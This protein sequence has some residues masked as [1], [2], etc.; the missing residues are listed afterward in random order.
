[1]L[2]LTKEYAEKFYKS[3]PAD[4]EQ[5][6]EELKRGEYRALGMLYKG[7]AHKDGEIV[8]RVAEE[9]GGFLSGLDARRLIRLEETFRQYSSLEWSIRWEAIE[10]EILKE[11]ILR[12][13]DYLWVIRLGTFHPN[14]YFR[15]NCIWALARDKA[16]QKYIIL[17]LND[18]VK[19][20]REAARIVSFGIEELNV[21]ALVE[22]LP[23]LEKVKQG[24]RREG[25]SFFLLEE[26]IA[27]GISTQLQNVDLL[28]LNQ[29]DAGTRKVLYGLL[30]DWKVLD[31]AEVNLILGREK[32][33][34]CL[35]FIMH[36]FLS[37]YELTAEELDVYLLHKNK[38]IQRRALEQKYRLMKDY[39]EGLEELLLAPSIGVRS[40]VCY[41]L[42]R[43]TEIEIV[44]FYKERLQT[45]N[46]KI[47]ILGI[48]ENGNPE[49]VQDLLPF[50]QEENGSI[51]KSALKAISMLVGDEASD[52]YWEYLQDER[53]MVIAGAYKEI[54]ANEIRYGAKKVYELLM[55]ASSDLLRDK[56]IYL[57]VRERSWDRLPYL[58]RLYQ[59]EDVVLR[60]LLHSGINRRSLYERVSVEA[61]EE[62]RRILY[63]EK[64][65]IPEK[66]QKSIEFDLKFVTK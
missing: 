53:P 55:T 10:P 28:H 12:Q 50:L 32:N 8:N 64:Y 45:G 21:E 16:S 36:K 57:L 1:M 52:I 37:N 19:Q 30:M 40:L 4:M 63:D 48:G 6:I 11:K 7:L 39:W 17:R 54:V 9:I 13:E 49:D 60:D 62:I 2:K 24:G 47:C 25:H 15:E 65:G 34:Q 29:Y 22:C 59:Y 18:W 23:Y 38:V 41:I 20:V 26:A 35:Q 27:K 66:L 51:V 42:K 33:T 58:L 5:A 14:G 56:L 43:H 61:A 44:K 46:K 3:Y 31:K